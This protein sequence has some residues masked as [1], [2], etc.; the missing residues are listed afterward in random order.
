VSAEMTNE[1]EQI[2]LR[3]ALDEE[4]I[5][6]LRELG[7]GDPTFLTGLLDLYLEQTDLLIA[8]AAAAVRDDAL[9]G[10][11]GAMHAIAGSSRNIGAFRLA[12]VCSAAEHDGRTSGRINSLP[13]MNDM[14][15]AYDGVKKETAALLA[16]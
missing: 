1:T 3:P 15:T 4:W 10:W 8:D 7:E 14:A 13:F 6:S 11:I 9:Q 5:D 2:V 16:L 12:D